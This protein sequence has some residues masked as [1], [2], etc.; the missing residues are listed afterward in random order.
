MGSA[1]GLVLKMSG[2]WLTALRRYLVAIGLGNLAWEFAQLPLYTIWHEGS[3][4]EI[5]FA[6]IHCTGGDMLIASVAL[7]GA[8]LFAGDSRWPEARF[9]IVAAVAVIGGVA[10]TVFSEW[11]NT[12]IRGSWAYTELMS[13][14]P[15]VGTGVSP[16]AQWIVIPL[17]AF[18]WA[19]RPIGAGK[20]SMESVS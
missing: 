18:W 14:L 4:A 1:P 11:L 15:L 13:L 20:Q 19:L 12:E 6:V 10:Y 8:L 16:I 17:A 5:L 3:T 9:R 7:L 2:S